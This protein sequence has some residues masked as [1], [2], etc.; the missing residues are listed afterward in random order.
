M[1][2]VSTL[3]VA[4]LSQKEVKKSPQ[5]DLPFLN[6]KKVLFVLLRWTCTL[7]ISCSNKYENLFT[8]QL[9]L[10]RMDCPF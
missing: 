7:Q 6:R 4:V 9:Y 10:S 2:K 3:L 1:K 5:S 8:L